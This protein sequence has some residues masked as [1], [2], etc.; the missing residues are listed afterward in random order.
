MTIFKV[1]QVLTSKGEWYLRSLYVFE[2]FVEAGGR[3]GS[4]HE[5]SESEI[6]KAIITYF[7]PGCV[8]VYI[9]LAFRS[10]N[11]ENVLFHSFVIYKVAY[12]FYVRRNFRYPK[13]MN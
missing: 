3:V 1:S 5:Y 13:L 10:E 2:G 8:E 11:V 4:T 12:C 6:L 9:F 7:D